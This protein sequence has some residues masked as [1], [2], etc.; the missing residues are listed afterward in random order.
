M[1]II[2]FSL[3]LHEDELEYTPIHQENVS[4][5]ISFHCEQLF[6][7][8]SS[9]LIKKKLIR[10]R[11]GEKYQFYIRLTLFLGTKDMCGIK[12][13]AVQQKEIH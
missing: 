8:H 1:I 5:P 3:V 6:F 4:F 10:I 7:N 13:L 2:Y 9:T 11:N 12:C